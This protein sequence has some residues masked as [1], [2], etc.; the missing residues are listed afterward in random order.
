[1]V[2]AIETLTKLIYCISLEGNFIVP[3]GSSGSSLPASSGTT[4]IEEQESPNTS[5][6]LNSGSNS[7]CASQAGALLH[8]EPL[9][10]HSNPPYIQHTL[11]AI[12]ST[13]NRTTP[14]W[15]MLLSDLYP[16]ESLSVTLAEMQ[17]F[18]QMLEWIQKARDAVLEAKHLSE[19]HSELAFRMHHAMASWTALYDDWAS[20]SKEVTG[21]PVEAEATGYSFGSWAPETP[22]SPPTR[23]S[24]A[25]P[26][27]IEM[28]ADE[29]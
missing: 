10:F 2:E 9:S 16:V 27:P 20:M 4:S 8:E 24:T 25:T 1:M 12:R 29:L 5:N 19:S 22:T 14:G 11:S 26:E 6:T 18:G 21:S 3:D 17:V 28:D 7:S 23:I 15:K 13:V